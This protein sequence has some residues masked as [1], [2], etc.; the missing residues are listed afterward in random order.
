MLERESLD[1]RF[2][3][4]PIFNLSDDE[5]EILERLRENG[6]EFSVLP[7]PDPT[8]FLAISATVGQAAQRVEIAVESG[9]GHPRVKPMG[10][11]L[12]RVCSF[13]TR[14]NAFSDALK[15]WLDRLFGS[16]RFDATRHVASRRYVWLS[17]EVP[18]VPRGEPWRPLG[19]HLNAHEP[20]RLRNSLFNFDPKE[21]HFLRLLE[22]AVARLNTGHPVPLKFNIYPRE[23]PFGSLELMV[24]Q[25]ERRQPVRVFVKGLY[26]VTYHLVTENTP[27]GQ[28][29]KDYLDGALGEE[30][31]D[32][33]SSR[34]KGKFLSLIY[35]VRH[36]RSV[37]E[38]FEV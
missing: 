27:V 1:F 5:E 4:D 31:L 35:S 21:Q 22:A 32:R 6:L 24:G 18:A 33:A 13:V 2:V 26:P 37:L 34:L 28:R 7:R 10:D 15:N 14:R 29:L 3:Q 17:Y 25:G 16:D 30:N 8:S 12:T 23:T 19:P 11:A 20:S 9:N 38:L 36:E